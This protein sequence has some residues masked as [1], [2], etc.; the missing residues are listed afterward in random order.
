MTTHAK[1]R[2]WVRRISVALLALAAVLIVVAFALGGIEGKRNSADEYAVYT[3]YLSNGIRNDPHDW[4]VG[5]S[6]RVVIEDTTAVGGSLRWPILFAFDSRIQ[7]KQLA[8]TT[9]A[10]YVVRNLLRTHLENKI[11][12]PSRAALVLAPAAEISS[13][14]F[15][16]KYPNNMGYIVLSGVGFNRSHTQAVFYI[17]HFCG[18]CGGGRYVLME[19]VTGIWRIQGEHYTWI[20]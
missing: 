1:F 17:D 6:I 18:L 4:S 13:S 20:S 3:A 15:Q 14:G 2:R 19:K 9:R 7:F 12:L 8:M 16:Q 5:P 10:S 11:R